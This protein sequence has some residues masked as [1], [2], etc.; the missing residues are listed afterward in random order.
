[1]SHPAQI[2]I[3]GGGFGGL[4]TALRLNRWIRR[5]SISARVTLVDEKDHFLFTPLLYELLTGELDTWEIAPKFKD[6]LAGTN[7][8]FCQDIVTAADLPQRQVMLQSGQ[9][10]RYDYLVLAVGQ[11]TRRDAVPGAAAHAMSFRTLADRDRL[12]QRLQSLAASATPARVAIVGAGPNGV[13]LACKLADRL[14]E[15]DIHLID[16]GD[17]ILRGFSAASQKSAYRA[18]VQRSIQLDLNTRIEALTP[19]QIHLQQPKQDLT[20]PAD[21]VLWTTG[22]APWDWVRSLPC[23]KTQ[24]GQLLVQPT[25]Q[26]VEYPEVFALGDLAT[27][28]DNQGQA[29]AA[30]A[31]SAFQQSPTVAQNLRACLTRQRL[32]DFRYRH[33]GEMMTL[34]IG[35][36]V[37]A[38]PKRHLTGTIASLIRQWAYISRLPT[39][40]HRLRVVAWELTRGLR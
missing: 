8:Q 10:L 36:A 27:V 33:Q 7:I 37:V 19:N 39:L 26:L 24:Q 22:T 11:Q 38:T 4:Y 14:D 20:L 18:L 16:L 40:K 9:Q 15:A 1:M 28:Q 30:T 3:L 34:G 2:C 6:L 17:T 29:I 13:E 21:I 32:T 23:S 35:S 31:Q 25:L 12:Q 5:R